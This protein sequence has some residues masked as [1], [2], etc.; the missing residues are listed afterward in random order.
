MNNPLNNVRKLTSSIEAELLAEMEVNSMLTFIAE[1]YKAIERLQKC[2]NL[3][4]LT[5]LELGSMIY[6]NRK[7]TSK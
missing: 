2:V 1:N 4:E 3:S 7:E 6:L 5:L